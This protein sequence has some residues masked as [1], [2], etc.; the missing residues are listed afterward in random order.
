VVLYAGNL[1]LMQDLD[2]LLDAFG[3]LTH[4][5]ELKGVLV[6]TG[7]ERARIEA[8]ILDRKEGLSQVQLLDHQS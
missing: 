7:I 5:P 1:G 3:A 8:R 6:G 2:S 4:V